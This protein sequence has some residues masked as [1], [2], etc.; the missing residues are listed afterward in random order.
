M[1]KF[2]SID[3]SCLSKLFGH[4]AVSKIRIDENLPVFEYKIDVVFFNYTVNRFIFVT[5]DL[6]GNILELPSILFVNIKNDSI[7]LLKND[8]KFFLR[9]KRQVITEKDYFRN[10][11]EY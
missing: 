9:K 4:G 10:A 11:K 6:N 7:D 3:D 1:F 8:A 5:Y 2:V